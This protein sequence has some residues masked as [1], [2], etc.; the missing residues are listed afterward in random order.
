MTCL[1]HNCLL[2]LVTI[3]NQMACFCSTLRN[4]AIILPWVPVVWVNLRRMVHNNR[5]LRVLRVS[6]FT[7][8]KLVHDFWVFF[9]S[10]KWFDMSLLKMWYF[11]TS[12]ITWFNYIVCVICLIMGYT[13]NY[14]SLHQVYHLCLVLTH[15]VPFVFF[16]A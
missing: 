3:S 7:W 15:D 13:Q 6:V 10:F 12:R 4:F 8:R 9:V 14:G 2:L 1:L 16:I 11:F 5:I